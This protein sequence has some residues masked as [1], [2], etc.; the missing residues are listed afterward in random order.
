[1]PIKVP[2]LQFYSISEDVFKSSENPFSVIFGW[3]NTFYC[4]LCLSFECKIDQADFTDQMSI[5]LCFNKATLS[6][7]FTKVYL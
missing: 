1:M 6:V 7:K 3:Y 2:G 5:P 4:H